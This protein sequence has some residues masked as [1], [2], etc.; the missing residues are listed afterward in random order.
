MTLIRTLS[1]E[2]WPKIMEALSRNYSPSY[3]CVDNPTY[4]DYYLNKGKIII[5]FQDF[6]I[7]YPNW[8]WIFSDRENLL[9]Q[10]LADHVYSAHASIY[11]DRLANI[12]ADHRERQ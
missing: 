7:R 3:Q 11:C 4:E 9:L 1:G 6:L 2:K 12:R 10:L 5:F 8:L